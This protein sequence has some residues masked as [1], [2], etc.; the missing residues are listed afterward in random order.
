MVDTQAE[1]SGL[2]VFNIHETQPPLFDLESTISR[3]VIKQGCGLSIPPTA[4]SHQEYSVVS[5]LIML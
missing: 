2:C 5:L 1:L 4:R 3:G